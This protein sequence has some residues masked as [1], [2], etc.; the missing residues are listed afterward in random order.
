MKKIVLLIGLSLLLSTNGYASCAEGTEITGVNGHVYCRSNIPLNWYSA[1][2]WCDAHGRTLATIEQ[3]C[4]V[5]ETQKWDGN[6][7]NDK[8]LNIIGN[9]SASN[10]VWTATVWP[11][12]SNSFAAALSS[13]NVSTVHRTTAS[14]NNLYA[15][16]W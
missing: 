5:D 13:G 8:C 3:M 6:V 9:Y 12:S 11:E 4:D 1:L 2:A 14:S 10:R 16:C 15:L 7:G